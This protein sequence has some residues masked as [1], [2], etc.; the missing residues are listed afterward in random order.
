MQQASVAKDS[1][2]PGAGDASPCTHPPGQKVKAEFVLTGAQ[3]NDALQ[4]KGRDRVSMTKTLPARSQRNPQTAE[5]VP[6]TLSPSLLVF[7]QAGH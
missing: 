7:A 5:W 3:V 1:E 2:P 6:P 4:T